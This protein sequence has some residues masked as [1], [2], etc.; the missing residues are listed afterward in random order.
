MTSAMIVYDVAKQG[1]EDRLAKKISAKGWKAKSREVV[2]YGAPHSPLSGSPCLLYGEL[3]S[4]N[5]KKYKALK[6]ATE[7]EISMSADVICS[8]S[9]GMGSN[10]QV[11]TS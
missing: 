9:V 6:R 10:T 3:S 8:T 5:E 11:N 4:A 1:Q 7:S 2:S